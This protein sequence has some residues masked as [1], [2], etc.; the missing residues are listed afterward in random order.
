MESKP[1]GAMRGAAESK[2]IVELVVPEDV[3]GLDGV[4]KVFGGRVEGFDEIGRGT[5]RFGKRDLPA[6]CK[7]AGGEWG[8]PVD[9]VRSD[10]RM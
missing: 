5:C 3:V 2:R 1:E 6:R 10:G 9:K 4:T 7:F 8:V